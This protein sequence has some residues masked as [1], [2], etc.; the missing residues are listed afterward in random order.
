LEHD[1][2]W[3]HKTSSTPPILFE[4]FMP[5]KEGEW[6]CISVLGVSIYPLRF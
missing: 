1:I 2:F 5:N 3:A 6:S 4:V